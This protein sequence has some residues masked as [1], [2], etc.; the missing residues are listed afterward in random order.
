[1]GVLEYEAKPQLNENRKRRGIP[2]AARD[3]G[4]LVTFRAEFKIGKKS[5]M[6]AWHW[7]G[8][9]NTSGVKSLHAITMD[10]NGSRVKPH[11]P[12]GKVQS[13]STLLWTKWQWWRCPP[14]RHWR[15]GKRKRLP[16]SSSLSSLLL[17]I[18]LC[19]AG[20]LPARQHMPCQLPCWQPYCR[21]RVDT[22]GTFQQLQ[23]RGDVFP[24]DAKAF[25][26]NTMPGSLQWHL[27]WKDGQ[28]EHVR[29]RR[30]SVGKDNW[31]QEQTKTTVVLLL[32]N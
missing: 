9:D 4:T 27:L 10:T 28:G 31:N 25:L 11:Y 5:T 12:T 18:S 14:E 15:R 1:M 8:T 17:R 29:T 19:Q 21:H 24:G 23:N 7:S 22:C 3:Y 32:T 6:P 13:V 20:S 2:S 16:L 30:G 26:L